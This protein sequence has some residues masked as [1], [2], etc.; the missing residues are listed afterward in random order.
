MVLA[1]TKLG[2]PGNYLVSWCGSGVWTLHRSYP[3]YHS[4][5]VCIVCM[6]VCVC[7]CVC[8]CLHTCV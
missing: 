8:A 6:C 4:L 3:S 5:Y 2:M 1:S 7:V